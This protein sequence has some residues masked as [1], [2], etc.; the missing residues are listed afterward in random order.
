MLNAFHVLRTNWKA[1]VDF[2]ERNGWLQLTTSI[3][4]V[5]LHED[6]QDLEI[7]EVEW[8]I[9]Q[10]KTKDVLTTH[11]IRSSLNHHDWMFHFIYKSSFDSLT[12]LIRNLI[13]CIQWK[14]RKKHGGTFQ[15][16]PR[17]TAS[18]TR[19]QFCVWAANA[20]LKTIFL[21]SEIFG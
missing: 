13:H 17:Q 19:E 2:K 8:S 1:P 12:K 15:S 6:P 21:V 11:R 4:F 7:C 18:K 14:H 3:G 5:S 20:E 16:K 9:A 10:C